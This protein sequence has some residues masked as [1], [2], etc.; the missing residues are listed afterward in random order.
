MADLRFQPARNV[1]ANR[2]GVATET[3]V[4]A[5]RGSGAR[6]RDRAPRQ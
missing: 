3:G 2:I 6:V 1:A 4:L 5:S